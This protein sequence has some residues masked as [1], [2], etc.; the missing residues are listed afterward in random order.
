[1]P[2]DTPIF[3]ALGFRK[4]NPAAWLRSLS[5]QFVGVFPCAGTPT[6]GT[7]GFGAGKLGVGALAID[8]TNGLIYINQGTRTS[9]LWVAA[10][11][12]MLPPTPITA[13]GAIAVRPSANYVITKAG[14][15]V[16]TLAAPT[17]G[18]PSAGGDDGT[19]IQVQSATAFAH[20]ITATGLLQTGSDAVNVVSFNPYA[21]ASISF[22]AYN[23]KWIIVDPIGVSF[24]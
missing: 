21:G 23:G 6:N 19:I 14:I 18:L 11:N 13:S 16:M 9:P 10:S 17:A 12:T 7:S 2:A 1:M 15:A 5:D 20:T 22:Q 4:P 24:S 8:V 3:G